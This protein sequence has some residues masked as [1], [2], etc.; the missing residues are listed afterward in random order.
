MLLIPLTWISC[1]SD[2]DK[3]QEA[4][5]VVTDFLHE[6]ELKN[7]DEV[8]KL[9]PSSI[10]INAFITPAKFDIEDAK[11]D[12]DENVR[13]YVR[14]NRGKTKRVPIMFSL[15]V[16][17]NGEYVIKHT[18]GLS[19]TVYNGRFDYYRIVG[20]LNDKS[21]DAEAER[22]DKD[23]GKVFSATVSGISH[24]IASNIKFSSNLEY[25]MGYVSGEAKVNNPTPYT[26]PYMCYQIKIAFGS[27]YTGDVVAIGDI[28]SGESLSF[29]VFTAV[30]QSW[31]SNDGVNLQFEITDTR[32]IEENMTEVEDFRGWDC[33]N[34]K[35]KAAKSAWWI[36][37]SEFE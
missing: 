22:T 2:E 10:D 6:L 12:D 5:Q 35:D 1:K 32:F 14:M 7:W 29:R 3:V 11:I 34:M 28:P 33:D 18:K 31:N 13:V 16:D 4:K 36:P 26:I 15:G 8:R 37:A 27:E 17:D 23:K 9:Y 20:C 30:P 21:D 24:R 19:P 25:S